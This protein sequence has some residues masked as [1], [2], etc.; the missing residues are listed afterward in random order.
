MSTH[1]NGAPGA[2]ATLSD[3]V[4][5]AWNRFW[6]TPGDP[7]VL[8]LIRICAGLITFYT[9]FIYSFNLQEFFGKHAW[10]DLESAVRA[11]HEKPMMTGTLRGY[12]I[13]PNFAN[14]TEKDLA[15]K[16]FARYAVSA[17]PFATS[18]DQYKVAADFMD[19]YGFDFRL[20]HLPFPTTGEEKDFL[21]RYSDAFH[22]PPA[23]AYPKTKEEAEYRFEYARRHGT[24]P[25]NPSLYAVG[26]PIWS[27][28]F[29]V[30]DPS[31]MMVVQILILL[32][33]FL[34][35]IG[36]CTRITSVLTWMANLSY[37]HRST[38]QLFGVDTMMTILLL[39]L[40]IG[41]SGA[42]WSVDRRIGRWWSKARPR[43]INRWRA[44]WKLP[45]LEIPTT[46]YPS[47]PQPSV[48][49]NAAMRLLQVHVCIVY[50]AAGLS[51]LMGQSW[52]NGT[53]VWGTIANYE[54]APMQFEA[55]NWFL[56]LLGRNQ[57]VLM[58]FLTVSSYFTLIFEIG[59]AF[60]I[61]RPATRWV[62]LG[63]AITLHGFIGLF[64][65]LKTFSLMML[66]MNMAFLRPEEANWA[67]GLFFRKL[68]RR[69]TVT[70]PA[71]PDAFR[72]AKEAARV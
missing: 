29:Y 46:R 66:V 55:Y 52:W 9:F 21:Y 43:I 57:L 22:Q 54:F 40:M 72:A 20:Y 19:R 60:L 12:E 45:L 32:A 71:P 3:R 26:T 36:F 13:P 6:F 65:G 27:I 10:W 37:I 7:T 41:P 28:W 14:E 38:V 62:M 50:L 30:T 56:R 23:V 42:A 4:E 31:A 18:I 48:S 49:A 5:A 16:Y 51:K 1:T 35:T 53:A 25:L 11:A 44:W 39:Y 15:E 8:G 63:M 58:G 64:M 59:Y 33:T 24:D 34:F 2:P 17:W 68:R 67:I 61:W 69:T 70:A 47:L